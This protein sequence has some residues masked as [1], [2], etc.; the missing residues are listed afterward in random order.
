MRATHDALRGVAARDRSSP[1]PARSRS[2]TRRLPRAGLSGFVSGLCGLAVAAAFSA[3]LTAPGFSPAA[4]AAAQESWEVIPVR[5]LRENL[6][7]WSNRAGWNLVWRSDN[8]DVD[9]GVGAAYTGS[10]EQAVVT[11]LEGIPSVE[12]TL[13]RGNKTLVVNVKGSAEQ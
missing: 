11:L 8:Y 5:S 1:A 2:L 3:A 9:L 12:A 10:Y 4:P 6:Q 7:G 13:Y